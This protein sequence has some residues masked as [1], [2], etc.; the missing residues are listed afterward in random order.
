MRPVVVAGADAYSLERPFRALGGPYLE[1]ELL[2]ASLWMRVAKYDEAG[3]LSAE[4][5]PSLPEAE[6]L[7]LERPTRR[8][9]RASEDGLQLV[10]RFLL[11]RQPD[12]VL[13]PGLVEEPEVTAP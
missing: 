9:N 6:R 13:L 2:P 11:P 4:L 8:G 5:E 1:G 12:A 10:G 7:V 3:A